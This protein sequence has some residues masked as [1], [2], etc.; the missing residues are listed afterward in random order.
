MEIN[1]DPMGKVEILRQYYDAIGAKNIEILLNVEQ[2]KQQMANPPPN[3]DMLKVQLETQKAQDA[4]QAKLHELEHAET[5]MHSRIAKLD[6]EIDLIKAQTLKTIAEAEAAEPGRQME[7]YK[8]E[9]QQLELD[10]KMELEHKKLEY[11][12]QSSAEG[13]GGGSRSKPQQQSPIDIRLGIDSPKSAGKRRVK[14]T[15]G[16]DGEL[17][18]ADIEDVLDEGGGTASETSEGMNPNSVLPA[19]KAET[20]SGVS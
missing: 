16:P 20:M 17:S 4:S 11:A 15:R 2:I 8:I 19:L 18:G 13:E 7:Q 3:P 12:K 10:R 1:P 5:E 9:L 6:A 14:I